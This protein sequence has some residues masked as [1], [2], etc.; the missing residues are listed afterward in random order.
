MFSQSNRTKKENKKQIKGAQTREGG[1]KYS[2]TLKGN[3]KD[4]QNK[5]T[6]EF[7]SAGPSKY[8]HDDKHNKVRKRGFLPDIE[9]DTDGNALWKGSF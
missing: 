6:G 4:G 7:I 8:R 1:V 2:S 9:A 3:G 5:G